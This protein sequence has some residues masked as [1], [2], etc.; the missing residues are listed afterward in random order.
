MASET[1]R[2]K[3]GRRI[4]GG[5]EGAQKRFVFAVMSP[6]VIF[7]AIFLALPIV[8]AFS[9]SFFDFSPRRT[10]TPFLGLGADNPF[11]GF[12]YYRA[13]TNFSSDSTLDVRQ[14]HAAVKVTLIFAFLVL[15]LNL[16]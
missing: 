6:A 11:V 15:P 3:R 14:F 16:L 10:G 5:R 2:L 12:K 1:I 8:W 9:L 13:M 7:M 4:F